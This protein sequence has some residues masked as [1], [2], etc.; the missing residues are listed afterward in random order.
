MVTRNSTH[1]GGTFLRN[2]LQLKPSSHYKR[3]HS[4]PV[5]F[6]RIRLCRGSVAS[7]N[8]THHTPSRVVIRTV[9]LL[10]LFAAIFVPVTLACTQS[11][12]SFG[13]SFSSSVGTASSSKSSVSVTQGVAVGAVVIGLRA[14]CFAN[15]STSILERAFSFFLLLFL[16]SF[17]PGFPKVHFST[18]SVLSRGKQ[19]Q[20]KRGGHTSQQQPSQPTH[21][22][23]NH[24]EM[25]PSVHITFRP[26]CGAHLCW[27]LTHLGVDLQC[28][29]RG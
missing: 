2:L 26:F 28:H 20:G 23:C 16:D 6:F 3:V 7:L 8:S 27:F 5:F 9:L 22:H 11:V 21:Y 15:F 1:A 12:K 24:W 19:E 10:P 18:A 14:C 29:G 4:V 17:D 13:R 25:N